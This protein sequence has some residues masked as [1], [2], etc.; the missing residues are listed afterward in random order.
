M[1][2]VASTSTWSS[3]ANRLTRRSRCRSVRSVSPGV[4]GAPGPI[5]RVVPE[6][7]V[8]VEVLLDAAPTPIEGVTGQV[9]DV[10]R[11]HDDDRVG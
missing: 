6:A 8:T 7:A 2:H 10:E 9:D 4:Q 3:L 5:E 11:V 1:P